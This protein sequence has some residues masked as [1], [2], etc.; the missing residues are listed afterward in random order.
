MTVAEALLDLLGHGRQHP[1]YIERRDS[2]ARHGV[3][4]GQMLVAALDLLGEQLGLLVQARA[5]DRA[6]DLRGH[7]L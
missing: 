6:A 4:H 3:Q 7:R 1:I 5:G 2:H